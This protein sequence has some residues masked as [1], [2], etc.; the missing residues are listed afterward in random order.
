[1]LR[2]GYWCL[3]LRRPLIY[4]C[5]AVGLPMGFLVSSLAE[6]HRTFSTSNQT[7]PNGLCIIRTEDAAGNLGYGHGFIMADLLVTAAHVVSGAKIYQVLCAKNGEMHDITR[8]VPAKSFTP[9]QYSTSRPLTFTGS[10]TS[11]LQYVKEFAFDI[12]AF[13]LDS[14]IPTVFTYVP[15]DNVLL[16]AQI[17]PRTNHLLS[18]LDGPDALLP[19]SPANGTSHYLGHPVTPMN[20]LLNDQMVVLKPGLI[21]NHF[22]A[23]SSFDVEVVPGHSGAPLTYSLAGS[24]RVVLGVASG[25]AV[26]KGPTGSPSHESIFTPITNLPQE[27]LTPERIKQRRE[28]AILKDCQ[29]RLIQAH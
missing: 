23:M 6:A 24:Q 21:N 3:K 9:A 2:N 1:M 22:D 5:L 8:V 4:F 12:T 17:L 20:Y 16:A 11:L 15:M 10:G 25:N 18:L 26:K 19:Q 28:R 7:A 13:E 29:R 14:V 27:L